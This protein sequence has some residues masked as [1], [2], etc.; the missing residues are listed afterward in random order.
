MFISKKKYEKLWNENMRLK[1]KVA[2]LERELDK[3]ENEEHETTPLCVGCVNCVK[4]ESGYFS[5]GLQFDEYMCK[6]NRTCKDYRAAEE[7]SDIVNGDG[8]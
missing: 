8:N 2:I 1:E 6:L 5:N 3:E 4:T 7:S